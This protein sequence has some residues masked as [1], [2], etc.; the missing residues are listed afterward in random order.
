MTRSTGTSGTLT[1]NLSS[2]DT[3]EATVVSQVTIFDGS[4]S[5]SFTVSA[6]DDF[7]ADGVQT[8]TISAAASGFTGGSDALQVLDN[9]GGTGGDDH[10]NNATTATSVGVPST[11]PGTIETGSD[12]DWFR[13]NAVSGTQYT[14]QTALGT[15]SDT[16]LELFGTN[17]STSSRKATTSAV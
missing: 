13:F 8:V 7:V 2:S 17:G 9:D 16:L 15:L 10:G 1:V 11:T 4:N 3:T 5:A 14:F 6:Q 12:A